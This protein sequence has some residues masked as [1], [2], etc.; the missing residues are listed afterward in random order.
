ME[1]LE[2]VVLLA[3]Q[4]SALLRY[5]PKLWFLLKPVPEYTQTI[6]LSFVIF[7]F[8]SLLLSLD[9]LICAQNWHN[10]EFLYIFSFRHF[11]FYIYSKLAQPS[12]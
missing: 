10:I 4:L 11:N 9:Y 6:K 12:I 5:S 7:L 3:P 2:R 8:I 1:I